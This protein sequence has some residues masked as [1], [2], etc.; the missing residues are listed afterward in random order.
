MAQVSRVQCCAIL[1]LH[2]L[3]DPSFNNGAE[4]GI[5][6]L[7]SALFGH[8]APSG[9]VG[10]HNGILPAQ[11]YSRP[12]IILS[13]ATSMNGGVSYSDRGKAFI[14]WVKDN[15]MGEIIVTDPHVNPSSSSTMVFILWMPNADNLREYFTNTFVKPYWEK[16]R[17]DDA[18][19][20]AKVS[21]AAKETIPGKKPSRI[22]GYYST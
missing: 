10:Y 11:I 9:A 2:G 16:K 14:D 19:A 15:K 17:A 1:E 21:E 20:A 3:H 4:A 22:V 18:K 13:F 6:N 8:Y 5:K 7:L 12:Y